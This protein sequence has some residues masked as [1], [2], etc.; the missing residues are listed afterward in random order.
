MTRSRYLV[1]S[2]VDPTPTRRAKDTRTREYGSATTKQAAI[3]LAERLLPPD[4]DFIVTTIGRTVHAGRT[5]PVQA[6]PAR[7]R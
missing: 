5:S 4:A 1:V 6:P 3:R 2:W 7:R